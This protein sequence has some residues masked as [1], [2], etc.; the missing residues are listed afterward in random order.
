MHSHGKALGPQAVQAS[1]QV[2]VVL[3]QADVVGVAGR[4]QPACGTD[5]SPC[6]GLRSQDQQQAV[7][8]QQ[9][10]RHLVGSMNLTQLQH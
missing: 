1:E 8:D 10:P 6:L 5:L 4:W 3:V 9:V 2:D 7:A